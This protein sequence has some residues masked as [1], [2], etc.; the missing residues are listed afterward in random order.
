[1]LTSLKLTNFKKHEN[2]E[3]NFTAGTNGIYGPNYKGK[4]TLLYAVLFALGGSAHVPGN[5]LARIGSDGRFKVELGFMIGTEHYTVVRTKS[6]ANLLKGEEILAASASAVTDE[7]EKLIGMSVKQWKELHYAKQKNAHSLLRYSATNLHQ[8]M[9]RLVG[10]EEL[11]GV[12]NRLKMMANKEQGIVDALGETEYSA[13]DCQGYIDTCNERAKS[14][15]EIRKTLKES[16]DTYTEL[17]Q[18]GREAIDKA[19]SRLVEIAD[20]RGAANT[21]K[22]RFDAAGRGLQAAEAELK[23]RTEARDLLQ[24]DLDAMGDVDTEAL[25][26]KADR[27]AS[28]STRVKILKGQVESDDSVSAASEAVE[29]A[30]R[31]LTKRTA[32]AKHAVEEHGTSEELSEQIAAAV[33]RRAELQARVTALKNALAGATCPTCDRPFDDHDPA[34]LQAELEEAKAAFDLQAKARD[35]LVEKR[36][37]VAYADQQKERA[38]NNLKLAKQTLDDTKSRQDASLE[39]LKTAE[40]ALAELGDLDVEALR[41]KVRD[42]LALVQRV[43]AARTEVVKAQEAFYAAT[44]TYN[45]V[46]QTPITD[47]EALDAEEAKLKARLTKDQNTLAELLKELNEARESSALAQE[48]EAANAAQ[49]ALWTERLEKLREREKRHDA[50]A[51]RL[52][53]IKH[54]Q[55]YLKENAESYMNKAWSSFMAHASQFAN[56]CTGGD[57]EGLERTEDGAFSFTEAGEEM[58]LEEASGAQEAIIGLAVQ[59]AL[60][61][62]APCHLNVLLLDEP[63]ADMDPDRS[64]A[65]IAA[66]S[67]LGQQIVFV[68]HHQ[69]DNSV[70]SNSIHL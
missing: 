68:S 22:A 32:E 41:A 40:V 28:L 54:L 21:A 59:L 63:T 27:Y 31:E 42:Y 12:Q 37:T 5:R 11:D 3:V 13:E 30:Q 10:A 60:A 23:A 38:Q 9:R 2:L 64:M 44:E 49:L 20:A 70:C 34:K 17:Q 24:A 29:Q 46:G 6:T 56:L 36:D 7:I 48:K 52:A 45:K 57:I 50:A 55:K 18:K 14:V 4:T 16:V 62:A 26:E 65:T 66:L 19:R 69:T 53:K 39:A 35:A 43:R 67:M 8:L 61:S 58:Q 47:V 51:K 15:A 33:E 25:S 1:M